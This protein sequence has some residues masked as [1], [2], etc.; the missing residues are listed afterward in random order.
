M[1]KNKIG[2][3]VYRYKL[4]VLITGSGVVHN[5]ALQ[6]FVYL[7]QEFLTIRYSFQIVM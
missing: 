5:V 1:H 4:Q 2:E 7:K 3:S 6:Y